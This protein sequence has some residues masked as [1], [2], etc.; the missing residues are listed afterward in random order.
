[1]IKKANIQLVIS[2]EIEY[3]DDDYV[4]IEPS[5]VLSHI[6]IQESDVI[7]GFEITTNIDGLDNTTD[8]FLQNA[9]I[10]SRNEVP[11]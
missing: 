4:G 10:K 5:D 9:V 3:D 1:M 2:A 8:F 11:V 7:D 6:T